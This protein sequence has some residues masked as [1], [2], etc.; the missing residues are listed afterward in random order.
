[1]AS[2][3]PHYIWY[4]Q[5]RGFQV[6]LAGSSHEFMTNFASRLEGILQIRHHTSL[7]ILRLLLES[8]AHKDSLGQTDRCSWQNESRFGSDFKSWDVLGLPGPSWALDPLRPTSQEKQNSDGA[9]PLKIAAARGNAQK[10][11]REGDPGPA[12]DPLTYLGASPCCCVW[13]PTRTRCRY[14]HTV[15]K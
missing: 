7:R 15:T 12:A 10:L 4:R 8:K 3:E 5:F 2:F 9:T 13:L 6:W 14:W 11:G 1:M